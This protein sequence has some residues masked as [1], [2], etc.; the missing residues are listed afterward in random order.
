MR[1][2]ATLLRE[3]ANRV[4]HDLRTDAGNL[5]G[6]SAMRTGPQP[7]PSISRI[8]HAGLQADHRFLT[9][10]DQAILWTIQINHQRDE[11]GKGQ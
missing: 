11:N 1:M 9:D 4:N 7:Q 2:F 8:T 3:S 5:P 10:L 6:M